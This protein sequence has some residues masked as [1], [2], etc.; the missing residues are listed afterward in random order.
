MKLYKPDFWD[1]K[2]NSFLSYIFFP[3]TFFIRLNNLIIKFS[4][5]EKTK[6]IFSICVGNIYV[7]GT[8]K[9]PTVI[10]LF[11]IIKKIN[12]KIVTAKKDNV[13]QKDEILLLKKKTNL[14]TGKNREEILSE[15]IKKKKKVIIFDDGLQDKKID[16]SLKFVC[17]DTLNWIGNGNLLPAGPLRQNL[18]VLK[19]FDVVFLKTINQQENI[20]IKKLKKVNPNIKI[21][22]T[23]YVIRN[24]KKINL[25]EKY[26]V[27]SSIGNPKNFEILLNQNKVK[28]IDY[29]IFPDHYLYSNNE[30]ENII[31]KAKQKNYKILTTEK[32]YVK[33][34]KTYKKHIHCVE[35]D[36][37]IK[38]ET[39]LI[40]YLKH[41]INA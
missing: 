36:L 11:N 22:M 25:K 33:I 15:A 20:I 19:K 38:N 12:N 13:N 16:Y 37:R 7:G 10:K 1:L 34:L 29:L 8:G 27:F 28:I 32:D 6:K 26:I 2:K 5:K 41:K 40:K 9:T 14:I 24:K 35:V 18:N 4:K 3:F 31:T 39:N 21:F 30:I 23:K 17:F